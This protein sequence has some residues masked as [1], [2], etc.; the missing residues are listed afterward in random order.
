MELDFI[1]QLSKETFGYLYIAAT[2]LSQKKYAGYFFHS[3]KENFFFTSPSFTNRLPSNLCRKKQEILILTNKPQEV[4][5]LWQPKERGYH[6]T[7][8]VIFTAYDSLGLFRK[9]AKREISFPVTVLPAFC[10]IQ[11]EKLQRV[12]E[13]KQ[14]LNAY[15]RGLDF[16]EHRAYRPGDSFNRID[17][18]LSAHTQEWLYREYD[19]QEEECSPLFCFWGS[20]SPK[21]EP[22][23]DLYF[24]LWHLRKEKQPELLILG[25]RAF[26]GKDPGHTYF[27]SLEAG[28][29]KAF[30]AHLKKYAKK[31]IVLFVPENFPEVSEAIETLSKDRTVYLVYF[32]EKQLM[33]QEKD[34][35]CSLPGGEWIDD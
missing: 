1:K 30:F 17:W 15:Q 32:V 16:R 20:P 23:L 24:S 9:S 26:H 25:N 2:R 34:K 27:A 3:K 5:L 12:L 33:V 35:I 19:Y 10:K 14:Q 7:L 4:Q 31:Q 6:E 11:A 29:E 21:F 22:L 13:K 28:D 8:T 18:K